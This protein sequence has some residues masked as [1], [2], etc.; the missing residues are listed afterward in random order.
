MSLSNF[1]NSGTNNPAQTVIKKQEQKKKG[2]ISKLGDFL[3]S[4]EKGFGQSLGDALAYVSGSGKTLD[5]ANEGQL[6]ASQ[7]YADLAKKT[8]DINKKK[9]Y[10]KLAGESAKEAGQNYQTALPSIKKSNL[11]IATEGGGV[12]LDIALAGGGAKLGQKAITSS[13]KAIAGQ[14]IKTVAKKSIGEIAKQTAKQVLKDSLV[15]GTYGLVV[16]AQNK[17]AKLKDYL[18]GGTSGAVAGAVLPPVIGGL[19][20]G[21]MF[22]VKTI[23]GKSSALL[24]K[25]ANKAEQYASKGAPEVGERFYQKIYNNKPS[26]GQKAAGV[27]SN[28]IKGIQKIPGKVAT[29]FYDKY[30]AINQFAQKAKKFGLD[31]PD[32]REMAQATQYRA[33]GKSENRL[34][35]YLAMRKM[36][37]ND[38]NTVKEYSNYLDD[39][40]RLAQGNKIAGNRTLESVTADMQKLEQSIPP[41]KLVKIKDGQRELQKFLNDEL[42]DAVDSGRLSPEQFKQIKQA[43]PNYIPHDVLDFLDEGQMSQGMGKSFNMAKSG[44]DKAKGSVREI[45]DIDNAVVEQLSEDSIVVSLSTQRIAYRLPSGWNTTSS[46]KR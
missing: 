33:A 34:D 43:H 21:G 36:Y 31:V 15:G 2:L 25:F 8:T 9:Q 7:Q 44:I 12:L 40:D 42:I 26:L 24:T 32:L 1:I 27:V 29:Q 30:Y 28:T 41:E 37:G 39:L 22:G 10:L 14:T 16:T 6:K 5:Q 45:D 13:A 18:I 38:W 23:A 20:K 19:T 17:G 35:D 11:Q 4:S 46:G 3:L